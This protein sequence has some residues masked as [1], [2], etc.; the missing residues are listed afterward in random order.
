[1][2]SVNQKVL[3]KYSEAA[4]HAELT[5]WWVATVVGMAA[6]LLRRRLPLVALA[7]TGG[8]A[9]VHFTGV[10]I[11]VTL[12]DAAAAVDASVAPTPVVAGGSRSAPAA[13]AAVR[14]PA[15][16]PRA[17]STPAPAPSVQA[18]T[19]APPDPALTEG[20]R[21]AA[22]LAR[23]RALNAADTV[24]AGGIVLSPG[25]VWAAIALMTAAAIGLALCRP[26]REQRR[27]PLSGRRGR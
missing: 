1:L 15:P 10:R 12:L 16:P 4:W 22:G 5:R 13:V 11:G 25:A 24:S 3:I 6:L 17:T 27:N 9:L 8:M 18:T 23:E 26:A 2:F 14:P 19:A 21:E 7:A 20:G